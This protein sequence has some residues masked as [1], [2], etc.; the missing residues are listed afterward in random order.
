MTFNRWICNHIPAHQRGPYTYLQTL[1]DAWKTVRG[2][3]SRE[4]VERIAQLDLGFVPGIGYAAWDQY[5]A[6]CLQTPAETAAWDQR[7]DGQIL[8]AFDPSIL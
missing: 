4:R 3:L 8:L 2:R 1:A 5:A 6:E 7:S